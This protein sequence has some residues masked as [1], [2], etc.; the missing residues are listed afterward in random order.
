MGKDRIGW[1]YAMQT[2]DH[3]H[4]LRSVQKSLTLKSSLVSDDFATAMDRLELGAIV[5]MR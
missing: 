4:T 2:T 5:V 1:N 3:V